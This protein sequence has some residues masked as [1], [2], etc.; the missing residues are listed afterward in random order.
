MPWPF[1]E[2]SSW[3][4]YGDILSFKNPLYRDFSWLNMFSRGC[5]K[6]QTTAISKPYSHTK[7]GHILMF[8]VWTFSLT[9]GYNFSEYSKELKF[10]KY[11]SFW[12]YFQQYFKFQWKVLFLLF[13]P[14]FQKPTS[15]IMCW[16]FSMKKGKCY[17]SNSTGKVS[18]Q[19]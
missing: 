19:T 15:N 1:L 11:S 16:K 3:E 7:F 6:C 10:P 9:W 17:N 14:A 12:K 2:G 5:Y 4:H 13:L 18:V 8:S